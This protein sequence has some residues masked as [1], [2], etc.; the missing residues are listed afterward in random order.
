MPMK[1]EEV[2]VG[3]VDKTFSWLNTF[4]GSMSMKEEKKK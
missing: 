3:F 2:K 1:Q 4:D